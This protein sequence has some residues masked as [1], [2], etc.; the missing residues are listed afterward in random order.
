MSAAP[1]I[2]STRMYDVT[3]PARDAWHA[4][5]RHAHRRAGI[6]AAFIEH[7][8][9]TPI[10]DLW[11]RQGLCGAFMCGWPYAQ[12]LRSGKAYAA[13]AAAAPDWPAYEGRAR[14]RSEFLVRADSPWSRLEDAL[15]TRYGWMVR[16]SQSGWNAPRRML[17]R[18]ASPGGKGLFRE[19]KGPYGNPRGLLRALLD[20]EIDV[21]AVDGWYLDLL[22][23]H[24]PAAMQAV[25]TVAWTDWTPNPLL[26]CGP[27]VDPDI[28]ARLSREL[29]AM[30]QDDHA[31]RLL[32]DAHVAR[33]LTVDPHAYDVLLDSGEADHYPD[34]R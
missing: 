16:D 5:L 11:A 24:D 30:H 9:P 21:T 29:C 27:D 18:Y 7:A 10:G 25:R 23:V 28:A 32:K 1:L 22:R 12:A 14:Y 33:F 19:T 17:A 4:L 26:V 8:W 31:A 15:G 34:I 6:G 20:G 3:P 2:A 13:V